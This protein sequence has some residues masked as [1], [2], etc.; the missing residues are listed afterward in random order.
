VR[1]TL[2]RQHDSRFSPGSA[3]DRLRDERAIVIRRSVEDDRTGHARP[4]A[5]H[6][7]HDLGGSPGERSD[8]DEAAGR[9]ALIL[10]D[11]PKICL[12][13]R[14]RQMARHRRVAVEAKHGVAEAR[15]MLPEGR[16][17][18]ELRHRGEHRQEAAREDLPGEIDHDAEAADGPRRI[19]RGA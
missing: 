2:C 8:V 11:A 4:L 9:S 16:V 1:K 19:E 15:E 6:G 10:K 12:D 17:A 7:P 14:R 18:P 5:N 13:H 3:P